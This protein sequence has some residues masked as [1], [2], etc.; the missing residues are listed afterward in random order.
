[1]DPHS[2]IGFDHVAMPTRNAR[3]A[4]TGLFLPSAAVDAAQA[5]VMARSPYS[6]MEADGA[7]I[8]FTLGQ[9]SPFA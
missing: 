2:S 1:M 5:R 9:A 8:D 4:F 3:G 7:K 6:G